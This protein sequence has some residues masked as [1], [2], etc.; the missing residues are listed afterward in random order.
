MIAGAT[1]Q[2]DSVGVDLVHTINDPGTGDV[3]DLTAATL[4]FIA[5]PPYPRTTKSSRTVTA[6]SPA[7]AGIVTVRTTAGECDTTGEWQTQIKVTIGGRVFY[8][9]PVAWDVRSNL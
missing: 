4:V 6:D 2:A 7:T 9:E 1:F 3:L 8:A 5:K